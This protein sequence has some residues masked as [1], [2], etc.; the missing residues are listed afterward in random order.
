M[1]LFETSP[2][3]LYIN[4]ERGEGGDSKILNKLAGVALYFHHTGT[5]IMATWGP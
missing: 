3:E 5:R 4:I 2:G 1:S